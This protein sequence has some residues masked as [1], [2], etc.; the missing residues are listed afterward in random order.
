MAINGLKT[1][2]LVVGG[3]IMGCATAYYLAKA[4]GDVTLVE[5]SELNRGA[6]GT[7]AGNLHLQSQRLIDDT[8]EALARSIGIIA[9]SKAAS[10]VWRT[11]EADLGVD[12]GT[13]IRGG[14]LVAETPDQVKV[15]HRKAEFERSCGLDAVVI[16]DTELRSLA[17][18]LSDRLLAADYVAEEGFANPLLVA[19]AMAR[20]AIAYGA[21][22]VTN[23]AVTGIER[24]SGNGFV[25]TTSQGVFEARR[26]VDAAGAWAGQIAA[27]IGIKLP[28]GGAVLTVN[29]TEPEP[30]SLKPLV[31]HCGR[32][33]TMKQTQYGTFIIGGGWSGDW[34][35]ETWLA[36]TRLESTT[37]NLFN[38]VRVMPALGQTRLLRTW[39]GMTATT[40]G[41]APII[42]E[43]RGEPGFFVLVSGSGLTLGPLVGRL[44]AELVSAGRAS[45]PLDQYDPALAGDLARN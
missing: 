17:P 13:R 1:D 38:A 30:F 27:M 41:Y 12:L 44:M 34:V 8:P 35:P 14:L 28:I 36:R 39:G 7:N 10:D 37:G 43:V 32:K 5:R 40:P 6:S 29:V 16:S 11:L 24:R 18:E 31:Q 25:V 33:L 42:G 4:G 15:L 20:H 45:L 26:I 2:V 23:C 22:V 3:G 21:T 19:P 9:L